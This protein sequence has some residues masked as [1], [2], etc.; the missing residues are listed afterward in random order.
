MRIL[1][2]LA[3]ST[4]LIACGGSSGGGSSSANN[5]NNNSTP[6]NV[7]LS[8]NGA[9]ISSTFA[10]NESFVN[11]G[12]TGTT[13]FWVAGA[14]GDSLT[15]AFDQQYTLSNITIHNDDMNSNTEFRLELS[16]NGVDYN[17]VL[18]FSGATQP[19]CIN[20]TLGSIFDC[21]LDYAASHLRL[22][23]LDDIANIR[24]YEIEATGQ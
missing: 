2:Y 19:G 16:S 6:T 23:L 1:I 9:S 15:I 17:E 8:S 5:N 20:L 13:N 7:A 10:G 22:T 3:L 18:I 24:I 21:D 12:D 14:A 11:D 4:L